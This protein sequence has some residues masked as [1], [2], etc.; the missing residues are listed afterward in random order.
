MEQK[1]PPLLLT[2]LCALMMWGIANVMPQSSFPAAYSFQIS[3]ILAALAVFVAG[4]GVYA[5]RIAKTT[6]NPLKTDGVSSLVNSGIYRFTRNPMYL[7]FYLILLAWGVYL[8]NYLALAGSLLFVFYMNRYQILPE[9][10]ALERIFGDSFE[11]YKQDVRRW[12]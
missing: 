8:T 9:E 2:L 6:M 5:F 3:M 11:R 7:G 12:I 4:C 1:I 10:R